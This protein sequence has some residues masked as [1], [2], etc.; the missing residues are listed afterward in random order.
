VN[1]VIVIFAFGLPNT[2]DSNT[3]M[4]SEIS[5]SN[6][7]SLLSLL[8]DFGKLNKIKQIITTT[9]KKY[10]YFIDFFVSTALFL[11]PDAIK[12]KNNRLDIVAE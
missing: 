10:K 4:S 5:S 6:V 11:I 8:V 12:N 3:S 9:E 7:L 2:T 1:S